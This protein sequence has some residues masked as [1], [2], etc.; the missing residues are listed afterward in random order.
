[1]RFCGKVLAD[2]ANMLALMLGQLKPD[3]SILKKSEDENEKSADKCLHPKPVKKKLVKRPHPC[4]SESLSS[5]SVRN[6]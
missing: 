1:M 3:T 6:Q 5:G 4:R 2:F